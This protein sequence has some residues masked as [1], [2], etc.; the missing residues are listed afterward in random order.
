L[1]SPEPTILTSLPVE[2]GAA[3]G[4]AVAGGFDIVTGGSCWGESRL[5]V[6]TDGK[7]M[8]VVASVPSTCVSGRRP[9]GMRVDTSPGECGLGTFFAEIAQ[10]EAAS[11]FA[12]DRL[13]RE[14]DAHGA[15]NELS[16]AAERSKLD[17]VRHTFATAHLAR[18]FGARPAAIDV[19]SLHVRPL[20]EIALEN[21][22][23]GCVR[24]TFGAL[25][26]AYQ[27]R[28]AKNRD[29]ARAMSVIASDEARHAA[30]AWE[31]A[32]WAEPQLAERERATIAEARRVAARELR[33]SLAFEPAPDVKSVAGMPRGDRAL[34]MFE[35]V[36]QELWA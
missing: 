6:S 31:V 4:A 24:E 14:L 32:A 16:R 25:L 2:C 5:F 10:L 36:E 15:P 29:V 11:V 34:A 33:A 8:L 22:V 7:E 13:A 28:H 12:F 30:L 23:E 19:G 18:R 27:A 1:K 21:A 3:T 9:E 26:A 20:I 17:E 35:H